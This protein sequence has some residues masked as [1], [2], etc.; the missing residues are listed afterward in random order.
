MN[1]PQKIWNAAEKR[2]LDWI[3]TGGGFDFVWRGLG[4]G[5]SRAGDMHGVDLVLAVSE[6][7]ACSPDVLGEP[8]TVSIYVNDPE[9]QNGIFIDFADAK[10]AMDF[11]ASAQNVWTMD[12]IAKT[13]N[14]GTKTA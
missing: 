4:K 6:D 12:S 2:G 9:W 10:I 5:E 1:I 13:Q 8:C 11:M 3:A 14:Q 7:L